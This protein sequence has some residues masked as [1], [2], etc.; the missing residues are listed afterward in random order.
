VSSPKTEDYAQR[1]PPNV[2]PVLATANSN[3]ARDSSRLFHCVFPRAVK[4]SILVGTR[5]AVK[6]ARSFGI[7]HRQHIIENTMDQRIRLTGMVKAAG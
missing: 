4:I 2:P 7:A 3:Y 6:A 1:D 5:T